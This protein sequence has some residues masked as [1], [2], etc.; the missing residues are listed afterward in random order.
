MGSESI[1]D[2]FVAT[3]QR[4]LAICEP[5][6]VEDYGL[7]AAAFASPPKWHLAHTS[8]FFET[9]LLKPFVADYEPLEPLY[10][11]LFN[12]YYNGIGD[13]HPRDQRGLLSRPTLDEV[14]AYREHVDRAM[15]SLLKRADGDASG[16][17]ILA[18]TVLGI[19]HERQHQ[20]LFFTDLKFSLSANPLYPAYV[21]AAIEAQ[22]TSAPLS[23]TRFEEGLVEVGHSGEEF[24]F[25]NELPRHR[26][27]L[28]AFELANRLVTNGEYQAFVDDGAYERPELWLADGWAAVQESHWSGPLHW[29]D[30]DGEALEFTLAGLQPR[31][32]GTPVSHVS[33]YEADAYARWAG[34]RL[35]REAEW[36]RVAA[37]RETA[38][39]AFSMDSFHPKAAEG[40][41]LQQL[42]GACWQWTQSAYSPYPGFAASA[43]AIGEYNGKFMSNQWVLRGGSCVTPPSQ[44]RPTYRNFFYPRD[45]WQFSGIR[46]AR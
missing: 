40:A 43:G 21:P 10:E 39:N 31:Q 7:Q 23:W 22:Q 19:E 34:A 44:A 14:L 11:V 35:P 36:E 16:K 1:T 4:F 37:S 24:C 15:L 42:Y 38:A 32:A 46:L 9:F 27:F 20:E 5:L 28:E 45:R 2:R 41:E 12:S 18:R 13:Q 17:D 30:R 26:V 3:R 29:V 6:E 33:G 25:D 8:W